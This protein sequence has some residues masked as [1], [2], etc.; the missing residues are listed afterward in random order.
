M[1]GVIILGLYTLRKLPI[2]LLIRYFPFELGIIILYGYII[3]TYGNERIVKIAFVRYLLTTL[4]SRYISRT[5]NL[6]GDSI[7]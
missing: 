5:S 6:G 3:L 1:V 7:K 2:Q 4:R